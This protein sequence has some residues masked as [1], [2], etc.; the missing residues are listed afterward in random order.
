[1]RGV[2]VADS[3]EMQQELRAFL[4]VVRDG[5]LTPATFLQQLEAIHGRFLG[6]DFNSVEHAK[7]RQHALAAYDEFTGGIDRHHEIEQIA[8]A[9]G[10]DS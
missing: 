9:L 1:M 8:H 5:Q 7:A 10:I 6:N 2:A 4:D 3:E